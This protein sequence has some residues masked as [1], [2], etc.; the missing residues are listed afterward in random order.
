[1][2]KGNVLITG[3]NRGLGYELVKCFHSNHYQVFPLVRSDEAATKL[4]AEFNDRCHPI[5]ADIRLDECKE[6]IQSNIRNF[7]DKIDI[8]I[9]NAG[10]PGRGRE[11]ENV[12]SEE[13]SEL[14]N[15]HCLGVLRVVQTTMEFLQNADN[16]RIINVSSR[17]GSLSKMAS[18]EFRNRKFTYSYRVAKAA[19]NMLTI[20]MDQEF[21][22]KG[23]CVRAI[24]PGVLKSGPS[25][26]DADLE[27]NE[28]AG[29]IFLWIEGLVITHSVQ[30][31]QPDVGE[32]PW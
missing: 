31:V 5:V 10:I 16:P 21:S 20:C 28:A 9:N 15:V 12:D 11:L 30:F 8:V 17:L 29:N 32:L 26:L 24:H 23:I 25:S 22:K 7:T 14:L 18:D 1:M 2:V 6:I 3:A 19:Q 13:V 4:M 27:A